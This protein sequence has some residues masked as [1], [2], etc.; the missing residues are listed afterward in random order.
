MKHKLTFLAI[1]ALL[2]TAGCV[3]QE[4]QNRLYREYEKRFVL[5]K[6]LFNKEHARLCISDFKRAMNDPSSFQLAGDFTFNT[7]ISGVYRGSYSADMLVP[8]SAP[9]RGKNAY[10]GL[11]LNKAICWYEVDLEKKQLIYAGL[12]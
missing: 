3:S 12:E 8:F 5:A 4:E 1:G 7:A 9:V 2:L 11:V 10:G 6:K